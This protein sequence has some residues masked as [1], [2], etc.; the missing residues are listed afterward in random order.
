MSPG[1]TGWDLESELWPESQVLCAHLDDDDTQEKEREE[2]LSSKVI[3]WHIL[4]AL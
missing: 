3:N 4:T 2:S 1:E